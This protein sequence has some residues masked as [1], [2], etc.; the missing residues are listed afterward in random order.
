MAKVTKETKAFE[1]LVLGEDSE[2]VRVIE[3]LRQGRIKIKKGWV[4]GDLAVDKHG[5]GVKSTSEEAVGWCAL[6]AVGVQNEE[7]PGTAGRALEVVLD[8]GQFENVPEFNDDG[9]TT[10]SDVLDVY[11]KAIK[12][13]KKHGV[14]TAQAVK[15]AKYVAQQKREQGW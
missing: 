9:N 1:R 3:T 4:Q 2:S 7:R 11:D 14:P 5:D 13:V 12:Y 6:G 15:K 10:Q 8:L